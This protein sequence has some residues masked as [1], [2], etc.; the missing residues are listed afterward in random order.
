MAAPRRDAVG[1]AGTEVAVSRNSEDGPGTRT[2][3]SAGATEG[4][5]ARTSY[6]DPKVA[7]S[8]DADRFKR[9]VGRFVDRLEKGAFLRALRSLP[10]G[11]SVGEMACG[12]G[13]MTKL[14]VD[15]GY[16]TVATDV[17]PAMLARARLRL[18]DRRVGG[19]FVLCDATALP[20]RDHS[21][22]VVIAYRFINQLPG[23]VRREVLAEA[24]RTT[25]SFVILSNLSPWS[26]KHLYRWLRRRSDAPRSPPAWSSRAFGREA[27][28]V[29]LRLEA[30]FR[31]LP[32]IA[33]TYVT[34]FS[35]IDPR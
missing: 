20:F 8:Y 34:R 15:R 16:P 19:G 27:A 30:V 1:P 32:I 10:A 31:I 23:D 26:L 28:A 35:R 25:R 24:A 4:Y 21:F 17:S 6:L 2:G 11:S 33:E 12:T 18:A 29:G 22:D 7:S 5:A 3:P 14:L 9:P 13:R